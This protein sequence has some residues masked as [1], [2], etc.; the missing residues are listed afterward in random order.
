MKFYKKLLATLACS[1]ALAMPLAMAD[2]YPDKPVT[3][4]VAYSPGGGNDTVAR[5][6][7]KYIEP[8]LGARMVVENSAGAGGQI[9]FTRLA[10]ADNDG[11]TVGLLSSPS[12]FNG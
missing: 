9:G 11:Y 7:T 5:L 3:M 6:M 12:I 10:K 8:Y 2:D 1:T 4:I